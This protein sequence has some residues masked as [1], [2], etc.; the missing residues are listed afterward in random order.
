MIEQFSYKSIS[1]IAHTHPYQ[2]HL[3]DQINKYWPSQIFHDKMKS[4]KEK[5]V[6]CHFSQFYI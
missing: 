1:E 4:L 6:S 3:R 2:R 5:Q